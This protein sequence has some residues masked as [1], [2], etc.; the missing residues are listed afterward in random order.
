[1]LDT[2]KN[3]FINRLLTQMLDGN[4]GSNILGAILTAMLAANINYA[5]ALAGFRF[6][7]MDNAAESAKLLATIVLAVFAYFVGKRERAAAAV[8]G[9]GAKP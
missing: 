6:D 1:M 7:N 8:Q 3:A 4:K 9:P 2:I 5:K